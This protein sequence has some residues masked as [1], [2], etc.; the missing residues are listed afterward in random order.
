[1]IGLSWTLSGSNAFNRPVTYTGPVRHANG[2]KQAAE[3]SPSMDDDAAL[4]KAARK[5]DPDALVAIFDRYA[6]ILYKYA[7]RLCGD[8]EEADDIV[9]DV[10]DLL[11]K[12]LKAGSGPTQNL[13]AYLYQ[14]AYHRVVDRARENKHLTGLDDGLAAPG[15]EPL[16][17]R[18]EHQEQMDAVEAIIMNQLTE[19]QRHVV[20]L[21]FI[22]NFSINE[23][24]EI[25]GKDANNVKVIQNRALAKLRAA[26]GPQPKES[27]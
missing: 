10:F 12:Y 6:P 25:V 8:F 21:R 24:A 9:G 26:L 17:S 4:L 15:A 3:R 11:L 16:H 13:R 27:A 19:D 23:T 14:I 18:H 7:L 20:M 2:R 5:L 22:E 1:M